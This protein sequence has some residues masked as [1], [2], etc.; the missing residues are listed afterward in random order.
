MHPQ[1]CPSSWM[2]RAA[3]PAPL[4]CIEGHESFGLKWLRQAGAKLE[5]S[6]LKEAVETVLEQSEIDY[7][8]RMVWFH[9][10]LTQISSGTRTL[11]LLCQNSSDFDCK[12]IFS[13]G[14][15]LRSS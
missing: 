5:D 15:A 10:L 8:P 13:R 14:P 2:D 1:C 11:Q 7:A 9:K 12:V 3:V 6:N 4:G